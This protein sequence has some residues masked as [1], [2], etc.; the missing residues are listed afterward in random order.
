MAPAMTVQKGEFSFLIALG[1]QL[2]RALE[3]CYD[4]SAPEFVTDALGVLANAL[5]GLIPGAGDDASS[6]DGGPDEGGDDDLD[7]SSWVEP[8]VDDRESRQ[9][10]GAAAMGGALPGTRAMSSTGVVTMRR[11]APPKRTRSVF[12]KGGKKNGKKRT[13]KT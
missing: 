13:R 8:E 4:G 6:P 10:R 5:E 1:K 11:L 12:K 3:M 7:P 9:R 2:D